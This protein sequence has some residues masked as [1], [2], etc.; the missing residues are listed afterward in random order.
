MSD[1]VSSDLRAE[2]RRVHSIQR[3]FEYYERQGLAEQ[4]ALAEYPVVRFVK[5]LPVQDPK[6]PAMEYLRLAQQA[7]RD[8][9]EGRR[10][11]SGRAGETI[12][13]EPRSHEFIT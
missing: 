13:F 3:R 5:S 8:V 7:G 12:R 4:A 10:E 1:V 9:W 2:F 6:Y 11:F